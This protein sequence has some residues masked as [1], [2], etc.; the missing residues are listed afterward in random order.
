MA[1][2]VIISN[3]PQRHREKWLSEREGFLTSSDTP[4]NRNGKLKST[5]KDR[6]STI[7]VQR[8][9]KALPTNHPVVVAHVA[10]GKMS[11]S[12]RLAYGSKN[13]AVA[14][15]LLGKELNTKIH[16]VGFAHQVGTIQGTSV[17]GLIGD[18]N[19]LPSTSSVEAK[20]PSLFG[21]YS[22]SYSS[23]YYQQC[24]THM[25]VFGNKECIFIKY[26][27]HLPLRI[28]YIKRDETFIKNM[29]DGEEKM[30]NEVTE[31]LNE[32]VK[33]FK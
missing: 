1:H 2:R 6:A 32:M 22:D 21:Y 25:K 12:E 29:I 7:A 5:W 13:E 33:D 14:L 18:L 8:L 17:D 9:I 20:C 30:R 4:Y 15:E 28:E 3:T 26:F 27:P 10:H 23:K 11:S 19:N 24:Q 16:S 31:L